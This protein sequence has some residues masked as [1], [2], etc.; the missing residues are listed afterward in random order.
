M[1]RGAR[2]YHLRGRGRGRLSQGQPSTAI[3]VPLHTREKTRMST[4]QPNY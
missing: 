3:D 2:A 4:R 1:E